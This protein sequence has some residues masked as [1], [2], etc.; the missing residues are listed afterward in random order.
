M[1][2]CRCMCMSMCIVYLYVRVMYMCISIC[3][4]IYGCNM[5]TPVAAHTHRYVFKLTHVHI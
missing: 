3:T 1:C 5:Y 4:F 2:M